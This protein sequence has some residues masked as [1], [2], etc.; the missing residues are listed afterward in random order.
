VRS[1][2]IAKESESSDWKKD[3]CHEILSIGDSD[4]GG[5]RGKSFDF[6][7]GEVTRR[8]GPSI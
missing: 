7:S 8:S 2:E 1:P 6:M 3:T 5:Q 4:I